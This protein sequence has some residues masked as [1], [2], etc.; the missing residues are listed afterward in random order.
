[1]SDYFNVHNRLF[2]T[3]HIGDKKP[4]KDLLHEQAHAISNETNHTG[5]NLEDKVLLSVATRMR[6]QEFLIQKIRELKNDQNYWCDSKNQFG[7]LIKKYT[8]LEPGSP[9]LRALKKV[10]ITVSSNIHL[11]SFMYEPILDLTID[12]LIRLYKEVNGL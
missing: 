4:T 10:S 1:M 8:E 6:S 12:H 2:G 11:N 3:N 9:A 7:I 5:L